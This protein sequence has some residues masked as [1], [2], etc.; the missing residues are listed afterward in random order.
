MQSDSMLP[1]YG[2]KLSPLFVSQE[3]NGSAESSQFVAQ[4]VPNYA[5]A[6]V[7]KATLPRN[8]SLGLPDFGARAAVGNVL[9]AV[10]GDVAGAAPSAFSRLLV[11]RKPRSTVGCSSRAAPEDV[12]R[13]ARGYVSTT[14][15]KDVSGFV[16]DGSLR[17]ASGDGSEA[18]PRN[19]ELVLPGCVAVSAF[20]QISEA[21]AREASGVSASDLSG[22]GLGHQAR[23]AFGDV[24]EAVSGGRWKVEGIALSGSFS[25]NQPR[26]MPRDLLR[27]PPTESVLDEPLALP[28]EMPVDAPTQRGESQRVLV[29]EDDLPLARLLSVWLSAKGYQVEVAHDGEDA[30][31]RLFAHQYDMALLDLNLPKIDG[32]A[33]LA[34]LQEHLP[35]LPVVVLTGRNRTEDRVLALEQGADDCLMKPFSLLELQARMTAVLRRS[36]SA[37]RADVPMKRPSQGL[38]LNREEYR[39]ERDGRKIELTPREFALLEFLMEQAPRPVSRA[40][41]MEQV[42]RVPFDPSTNIVDV[43]MKYLRDKIDVG[44]EQ[45]LI[46]TVRGVGYALACA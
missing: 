12:P 7:P 25:G 2:G 20:G 46:R 9:K 39:V 1:Q 45:K 37:V 27:E 40:T 24:P 44:G 26:V 11:G 42:W 5:P 15:A 43:Y 22:S 32:L 23:V 3:A 8:A 28:G 33:L 16:L 4:N 34:H 14:L 19:V 31:A 29:V 41:L 17:S 30:L 36:G 38:M 18:M 10:A 13:A 21:V 35:A 6:F